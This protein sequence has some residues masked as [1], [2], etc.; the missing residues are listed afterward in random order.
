MAAKFVERFSAC[1]PQYAAHR[2]SYPAVLID[3]LADTAD[4]TNLAW[5]CGCGSGQL[6]APLAARFDRVFATDASRDQIAA[7]PSADNV[8]YH[9]A[10]ADASGLPDRS[11]DLAVAA[12]AA[13]W[14]PLEGYYREVRRVC[15]PGG[16]H[17]LI[18][19]GMATVTPAIDSV[20][21]HFYTET[22]GPYWDTARRH[23][24]TG[25]RDLPFPFREITPPGFEIRLEWTV[26]AYL[27]YIE[28]WSAVRKLLS[29][30]GTAPL[31]AFGR[32]LRAVWNV[33]AQ[34]LIRWPISMRVGYV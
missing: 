30:V 34:R 6:S 31:E 32:E 12:Q 13:H 19:Y 25:Y 23:V 2:P 4:R 17:A 29:E 26:A 18:S 27:G 22:T 24:E 3:W 1:A 28:T 20:V 16:L 33:Q 7:A 15:V 11:V 21:N 10:F 14:F 9:V 8:E 5:D